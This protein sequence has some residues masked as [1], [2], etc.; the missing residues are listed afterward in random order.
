MQSEPAL[1]H[2]FCQLTKSVSYYAQIIIHFDP[3][4]QPLSALI[5]L[6]ERFEMNVKSI[7][8][9][10]SVAENQEIALVKLNAIDVSHVVIALIEN[11]GVEA[12]GCGPIMPALA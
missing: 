4:Q 7:E 6:I 3:Q 5:R 2:E 12:F 8:I 10:S 9:V 1:F 11:T